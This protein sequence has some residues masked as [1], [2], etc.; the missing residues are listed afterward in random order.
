MSTWIS[1]ETW[2]PLPRREFSVRKDY[3]VLVGTN[4]HTITPDGWL[5]EENNL[6]R[7]L[8]E[9]RDLARRLPGRLSRHV[10]ELRH[11][12]RHGLHQRQP[13]AIGAR[14]EHRAG[15][16]VR[17]VPVEVP[18]GAVVVAGDLDRVVQPLGNEPAAYTVTM[19]MG[20]QSMKMEITST[21]TEEGNT[22]V[23]T[24]TATVR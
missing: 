16:H 5:Q 11:R 21:V 23:V 20:A 14:R 24:D 17:A 10:G 18:L 1:D 7:V 4:R 8:P 3:E 2:R 6:K 19:A 22:V 9:R 15:H 12:Q 13:E